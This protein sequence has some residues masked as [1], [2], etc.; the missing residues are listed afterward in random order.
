M[1][2]RRFGRL[3]VTNDGKAVTLKGLGSRWEGVLVLGGLLG[4]GIWTVAAIGLLQDGGVTPESLKI[5]AVLLV[6]PVIFGYLGY[7]AGGRFEDM[8]V[9]YDPA[10][11][12]VLRIRNGNSIVEVPISSLRGFETRDSWSSPVTGRAKSH[13]WF[14]VALTDTGE[15]PLI[16]PRVSVG[17]PQS[18]ACCELMTSLILRGG[19]A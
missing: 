8:G 19:T 18:D 1:Q 16:D 11:G 14:P 5:L 2:T 12:K 6:L 3:V 15:I 17:R 10:R 9:E 4:G 7:Q 13:F